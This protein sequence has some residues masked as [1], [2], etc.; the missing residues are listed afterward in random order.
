MTA[1]DISNNP[2][3]IRLAEEVAATKK[4]RKLTRDSKTVAILMPAGTAVKPKKKGEKTQ[5]DYE[6]FRSAA[7]SWNDVDTDTFLKHIYADRRR[8]NTRLPVKL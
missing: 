3:L 8:T 4:P 5:A 6:A 2:E 1:I 7:G